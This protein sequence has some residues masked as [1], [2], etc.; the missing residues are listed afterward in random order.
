MTAPPSE[1]PRLPN[2]ALLLGLSWLVIVA[3]LLA[4]HWAATAQTL[5]DTDDAM[6]LV[7][8]R[9]FLAGHG[10][11]DLHEMRLGPPDGYDT[12][13]SRLIDAGLAGI[14]LIFHQFVDGAMAERLAR[15]AWPMLWLLPTMA[16]AAA[17]ARR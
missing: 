16:G 6:R 1:S 8:M 13:W 17:I 12:H 5:L 14:Y 4:T 15:T 10:W 11:F 9:A 3:Q 2:M 7:Q